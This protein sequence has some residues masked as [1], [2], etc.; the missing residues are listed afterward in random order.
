MKTTLHYLL[1]AGVLAGAVGSVSAAE[2]LALNAEQLDGVTAAGLANAT[3]LADALGILNAAQ[4]TYTNAV[5]F[6][7]PELSME[8][9]GGQLTYTFSWAQAASESGAQ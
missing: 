3:A 7:S 2:P 5:V 9:Q 1:M 8:T 4:L 6:V